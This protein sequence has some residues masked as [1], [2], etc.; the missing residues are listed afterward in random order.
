MAVKPTDF[1]LFAAPLCESA[2]EIDLRNAISRS[3][4]GALHHARAKIDSKI[5]NGH[6]RYANGTH[7]QVIGCYENGPTDGHKK[8]AYLLRDYKRQREEADYDIVA[9]VISQSDVQQMHKSCIKLTGRIDTLP[10]I[11]LAAP[12]AAAPAT[13][14]SSVRPTLTIIK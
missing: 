11:E 1:F 12:P 6:I 9:P 7:A 4:Y 13:A 3:Y 5:G 2:T 10:N 14:P 8:I